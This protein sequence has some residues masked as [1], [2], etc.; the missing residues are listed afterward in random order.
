MN[1]NLQTKVQFTII[2]DLNLQIQR[3]QAR[4]DAACIAAIKAGGFEDYSDMECAYNDWDYDE[5]TR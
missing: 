5:K 3:L 1:L 2:S 4:R